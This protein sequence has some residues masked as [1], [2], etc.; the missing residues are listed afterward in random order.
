MLI[1]IEGPFGWEVLKGKGF[2]LK[3][4]YNKIRRRVDYLNRKEFS[5]KKD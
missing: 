4:K 5:R 1:W 2:Q 3:V